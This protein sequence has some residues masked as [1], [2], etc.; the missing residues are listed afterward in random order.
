[1]AQSY[2][3]MFADAHLLITGLRARSQTRAIVA[4]IA[5]GRRP[6]DGFGIKCIR[7]SEGAFGQVP[8]LSTTFRNLATAASRGG[9]SQPIARGGKQSD[10]M[11]VDG[12][13]E[14]AAVAMSVAVMGSEC[15]VTCTLRQGAVGESPR[16]VHTDFHC[17]RSCTSTSSGEAERFCPTPTVV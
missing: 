14:E 2:S 6:P 5:I 7:T 10:P 12:L 13:N 16:R 3:F 9:D 1:M 8:V 17:A 15:R 4:I 11:A